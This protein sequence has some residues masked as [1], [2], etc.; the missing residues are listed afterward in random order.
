[1]H[2]KYRNHI[3]REPGRGSRQIFAESGARQRVFPR[4]VTEGLSAKRWRRQGRS[5]LWARGN[6]LPRAWFCRERGLRQRTVLPTGIFCRARLSA[7]RPTSPRAVACRD[8]GPRQSCHLPTAGVCREP[9]SANVFFAESPQFCSRQKSRIS[10]KGVF[11]VVL[12]SIYLRAHAWLDHGE[13][14]YS[15][16][17][18]NKIDKALEHSHDVNYLKQ[19]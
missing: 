17:V 5:R 3:C 18:E 14:D 12:S 13:K 10:A 9:R 1:M 4:A 16:H 2:M 11:P 19:K 7:K 15:C 6:V 8:A